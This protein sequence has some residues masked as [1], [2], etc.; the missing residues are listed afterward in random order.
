MSRRESKRSGGPKTRVL[1]I[2]LPVE[3][4][5]RCTFDHG[6]P[7]K[8]RKDSVSKSGERIQDRLQDE[9][10]MVGIHRDGPR[11]TRT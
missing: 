1:K 4:V 10:R 7:R 3:E 11:R 2:G 9:A 8:I 6:L 5:V